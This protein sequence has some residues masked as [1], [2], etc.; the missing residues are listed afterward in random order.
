MS[1]RAQE[2]YTISHVDSHE[3]LAPGMNGRDKTL[4]ILQTRTKARVGGET[5]EFVPTEW[6]V[7]AWDTESLDGY[8]VPEIL[9]Q[10]SAQEF[11]DSDGRYVP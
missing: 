11:V 4:A 8:G 1:G 5:V 2:R 9:W 6:Y 3:P 10:T 7:T